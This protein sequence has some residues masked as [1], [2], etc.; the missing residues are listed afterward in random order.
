MRKEEEKAERERRR[1][2]MKGG[3]KEVKVREKKTVRRR[4]AYGSIV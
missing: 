2:R 3:K 4:N 1:E